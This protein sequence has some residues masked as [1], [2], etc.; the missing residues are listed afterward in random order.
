MKLKLSTKKNGR[1]EVRGEKEGETAET[2]DNNNKDAGQDIMTG[3]VKSSIFSQ[4]PNKGNL[5]QK[6]GNVLC[7]NDAC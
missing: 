2:K 6:I 1:E 4:S 5:L 3:S 7:I